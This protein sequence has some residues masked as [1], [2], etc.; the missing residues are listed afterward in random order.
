M[1]YA[2][3]VVSRG[4]SSKL[5]SYEGLNNLCFSKNEKSSLQD[6]KRNRNKD[7][8]NSKSE[9]LWEISTSV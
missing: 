6:V 1:R 7:Y 3:L 2:R 8:V 9:V 5:E 4:H